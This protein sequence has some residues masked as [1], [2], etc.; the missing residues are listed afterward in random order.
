MTVAQLEK[1]VAVLEKIVEELRAK[2]EKSPAE[3][4]KWWRDD[5]GRFAN[6]PLFDEM[7]QAVQEYRESL[8]PHLKKK[9]R[10]NARS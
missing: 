1:R 7:V 5:A 10:K 3:P 8:D 9:T 2:V 6:D 4:R